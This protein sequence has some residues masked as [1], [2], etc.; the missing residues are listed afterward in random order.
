MRVYKHIGRSLFPVLLSAL[1]IIFV[2]FFMSCGEEESARAPSPVEEARPPVDKAPDERDKASPP[3]A[4]AP[5]LR[6]EA[7]RPEAAPRKKVRRPAEMD[8]GAPKMGPPPASEAPARSPSFPWPPPK[9]SASS[10]V[11]DNFLRETETKQILHDIDR[12]LALALDKAGYFEKS[13]FS[14]PD[15]FAL[16]TRLEQINADGTPK[17]EP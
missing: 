7:R 12:R 1:I 14:V 4:E 9:A 11:P 17:P 5:E 2:I 13:Y 8:R 3:A 10:K 6:R 16:V 15:G